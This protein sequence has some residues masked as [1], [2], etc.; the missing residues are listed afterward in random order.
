MSSPT[1]PP[2]DRVSGLRIGWIGAVVVYTVVVLAAYAN[3]SLFA[4]PWEDAPWYNFP[5]VKELVFLLAIV[6]ALALGVAEVLADSRRPARTT[7]RDVVALSVSVGLLTLFFCEDNES[8][9]RS[10][11]FLMVTVALCTSCGGCA[12]KVWMRRRLEVGRR[13]VSEGKFQHSTKKYH[14]LC[15]D[16]NDNAECWI[17]TDDAAADLQQCACSRVCGRHWTRKGEND[18]TISQAPRLCK[19]PDAWFLDKTYLAPSTVLLRELPLW[20]WKIKAVE[21]RK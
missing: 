5:A 15:G 2:E 9:H 13:I 14:R 4:F 1:T 21:N 12:R 17:G 10:T 18:E 8:L 19:Y 6:L 20:D 11:M 16:S 3:H 7:V